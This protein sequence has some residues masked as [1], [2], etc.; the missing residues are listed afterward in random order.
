MVIDILHPE[1]ETRERL[2]KVYKTTSNVTFVFGFRTHL[3][4]GRTIGFGMIYDSL[5]YMK[6]NEPTHRHA[7]HDLYEK[8]K[9]TS[10]K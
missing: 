10:R 9:K 2:D 6:K 3:G 5:H 8:K 4:G 1:M 7:R